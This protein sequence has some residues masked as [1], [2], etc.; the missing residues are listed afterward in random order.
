MP[1]NEMAFQEDRTDADA[2]VFIDSSEDSDDSAQCKPPPVFIDSSESSSEDDNNNDTDNDNQDED[3]LGSPV[4]HNSD[5]VCTGT[6]V[7]ALEDPV[8]GEDS[9]A[10]KILK[11][12]EL[13]G[14]LPDILVPP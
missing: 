1:G 10:E 4:V 6:E 8:P 5:D 11:Y 14:C 2:R 9:Y 12:Y 7:S 3:D 13:H